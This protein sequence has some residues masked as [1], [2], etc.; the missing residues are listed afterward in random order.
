[1]NLYFSRNPSPRVAV[2]VAKYLRLDL[3]FAFAAPKAPG[4]AENY[5]HLNPNLL[6]PILDRSGKPLWETDAI[7][8]SLSRT[9]QSNFW[10]CD[11][12]EP[13]MIRW[14]SWG[15]ENFIKACDM[16][17]WERGTKL[18]YGLGSC[19]ERAVQEG[20]EL[21]HASAALLDAE[22]STHRWLVGDDISYADF[23][24]AT[25]L[26]FN[27]VARLPVEQYPSLDRWHDQLEQISAWQNPFDGLSAPALPAVPG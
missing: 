25:F 19:D 2:A 1:M 22:L 23:R 5:R 12:D 13:E 11:D 16:V 7:A 4:E 8:C 9:A 18:R 15:K 3:E 26:P 20:L 24:L 17:H 6:L 14:I 27:D 21:F 10:R